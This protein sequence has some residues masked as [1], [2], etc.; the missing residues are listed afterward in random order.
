MRAPSPP[1]RAW[2]QS[3]GDLKSVPFLTAQALWSRNSHEHHTLQKA[4]FTQKNE[5][6]TSTRL[7][8]TQGT[9]FPPRPAPPHWPG[10]LVSVALL[11]AGAPSPSAPPWY[12]SAVPG[13]LLHFRTQ[14]CKVSAPS[15]HAPGKL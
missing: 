7:P 13:E 4:I 12:R 14:P 11:Q 15:S 8:C 10:A 3:T 5:V 6:L 1:P 9:A 2:I